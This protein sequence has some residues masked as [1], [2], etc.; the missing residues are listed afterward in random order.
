MLTLRPLAPRP[1]RLAEGLAVVTGSS[2]GIGAALAEQLAARGHP[3]LLVAPPGEA[4][5]EQALRLSGRHDIPAEPMEADLTD[6]AQL[7]SVKDELQRRDVAIL[8]NNAGVG[9]FG[10]FVRNYT[11]AQVR[12]DV[13]AVAELTAAVLPGMLSRN[14]GALLHVGS[15]AGNQPVPG[16]ATYA[17]AKAFVNSLAEALHIELAGTGVRCTLLA[18]GPVHTD[19]AERS[20]VGHA[21][22]R[23][24]ELAWVSADEAAAAGL[25]GLERNQRRVAPGVSGRVFDIG[26]RLTPTWL[27]GPLV[28]RVIARN[29]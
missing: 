1:N 6:A 22:A 4:L 13:L 25:R 3:L 16:A 24:P 19:F 15:T 11:A 10:D 28:R 8:C 20:G 26:G 17:A 29:V 2:T 14:A 5:V 18:P 7:S 27:S 21:A 23:I 12:L 9:Q